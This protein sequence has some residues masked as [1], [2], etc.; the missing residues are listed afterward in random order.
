MNSSG[1]SGKNV[2]STE[3]LAPS[4]VKLAGAVTV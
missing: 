2:R 1:S 4:T 3:T